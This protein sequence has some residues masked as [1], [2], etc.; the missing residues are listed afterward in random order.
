MLAQLPAGQNI[1]FYTK[2]GR[3][4]AG[5]RFFTRT[6]ADTVQVFANRYR[7]YSIRDAQTGA[8]LVR[9]SFVP[10]DDYVTIPHQIGAN[11]DIVI[12]VAS[13]SDYVMRFRGLSPFLSPQ[14]GVRYDP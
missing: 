3:D 8:V 5:A 12:T 1:S 9:S 14:D 13:G 10:T 11:R 2:G 6:T 7:P 4:D